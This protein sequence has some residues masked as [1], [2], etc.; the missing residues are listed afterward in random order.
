MPILNVIRLNN[1]F[2]VSVGGGLPL[3]I[4]SQ[5]QK[6]LNLIQDQHFSNISE[7]QKILNYPGGGVRPNWEFFPNIFG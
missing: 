7:I 1:P 6:S 4:C 2:Q 5:I 3:S